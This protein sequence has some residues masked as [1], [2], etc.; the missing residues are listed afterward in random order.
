MTKRATASVRRHDP[1]PVRGLSAAQFRR[2]CEN[3]FGDGHNS[4]PHSIAWYQDHL[5]VGTT[6]SNF[7]MAKI[8]TT[9]RTLPVYLW[10]VEGPDDQEGLYRDLDRRAQVWRYDPRGDR[11]D[12]VMVAPMVEGTRGEEVARE[13]GHRA[14]V[15]Y[16][17]ESDTKP[18]LYTATW[19]VSRSPGAL[20]LR[21]E[22]GE[23]FEPVSP[24]GIIEGMPITATRVLVPF[25]DRLFTSPTGT[26][27]H[28]VKFVINVSGAPVIYESR[29]PASG[30]WRASC[31]PGF[32]DPENKGVFML[33]PFNDQ[34]YA[35]TFNNNGFQVWRSAC[36]GNPPYKWTRVIERGAYRGA[37]NQAVVSMCAFDGALYVGSGIQNGGHDLNNK[38]GPAGSELIR[39]HP[40]D[41]WDLIIGTTRETPAGRKAPLSGLAAGFGNIFNGYFWSMAEHD[42]WLYMGTNDS[43][44]W[45]RFLSIDAYD[46]NVRR[47]IEGVGVDRILE[48]E[49]GCDLWRSAD[50]EN[51]MPVTRTGF[52]NVY[53]L[54]VRNLAS[55]PCGL[56]AAMA[57]PFGPRVASPGE[58]KWGYVDNPRGGLEI[59]RGEAGGRPG[60][61]AV[62]TL[63]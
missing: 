10:P 19:A 35:G 7:Q 4:F 27:G 44:V 28:D 46:P 59:W 49:G 30:K 31:W 48:M 9:F 26:R 55:T 52:D 32:A 56:F 41:S 62:E 17:G 2:V 14:M 47:V 5:Y 12:Q 15:V 36:D 53:N 6:R 11:W 29:D 1:A 37:L 24:Y 20:L 22:D 63:G 33:C 23:N 57:N 50:G 25:K 21:S 45:M 13:T 3:G 8:Q 34:L 42:G 43:I 60:A 38:I 51:W 16:Q 61:G 58:G 39:I 40:D 18:V 54:G